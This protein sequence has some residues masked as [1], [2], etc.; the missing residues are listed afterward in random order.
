MDIHIQSFSLKQMVSLHHCLI[1]LI[2]LSLNLSFQFLLSLFQ[3]PAKG[4]PKT[5]DEIQELLAKQHNSQREGGCLG[6]LLPW[7]VKQN[8]H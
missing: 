5:L 1:I 2:S 3:L 8:F 7:L 6:Q 4:V